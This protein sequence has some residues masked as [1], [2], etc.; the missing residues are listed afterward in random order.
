MAERSS[1][2]ELYQVAILQ[3]R[4]E[5][6]LLWQRFAAFLTPHTIFLAFVLHAFSNRQFPAFNLWIFLAG[7]LGFVLCIPWLAVYVR[8]SAYYTFRI[9][10]A[11][12]VE[13]SEWQLLA[14]IAEKFSAGEPVKVRDNHRMP[15]LARKLRTERAG[16]VMIGIFLLVYFALVVVAGPWWGEAGA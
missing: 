8:S 10:Q 4:Y 5:G 9:A 3:V 16:L 15:W 12:E 11:R 7:I 1:N 2:L 6:Q 13:P 14:G